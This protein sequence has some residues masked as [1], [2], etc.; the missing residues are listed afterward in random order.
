MELFAQSRLSHNRRIVEKISNSGRGQLYHVTEDVKQIQ[1]NRCINQAHCYDYALR[2]YDA[3]SDIESHGL[4][5][6]L[7]KQTQVSSVKHEN[8]L[9]V[10]DVDMVYE[11]NNFQVDI[12][13][14]AHLLFLTELA[15]GNLCHLMGRPEYFEQKTAHQRV[16][17]MN[18]MA[19]GI[20]FLHRKNYVYRR[21]HPRN[22]MLME[23]TEKKMFL[24][25]LGDFQDLTASFE[26][27]LY[28]PGDIVADHVPYTAPEI[29]MGY[30]SYLPA[31]DVWAYGIVLF[32]M[33]FGI[34][35][36]PFFDMR[37]DIRQIFRQTTKDKVV[38]NIFKW[39][40]TP[41]VEWRR[42]YARCEEIKTGA[43]RK[44]S[45]QTS[46]RQMLTRNDDDNDSSPPAYF[47]FSKSVFHSILD[48]IDKCLQLDPDDRITFQDILRHPLFQKYDF[49]V[50]KGCQVTLPSKPSFI[51]GGSF[52]HFR[53]SIVENTL[54]DIEQGDMMYYPSLLAM[55]IFDRAIP[56]FMQDIFE[57]SANGVIH[58]DFVSGLFCTCYLLAVKLLVKLPNHSTPDIIN[59]HIKG[60]V[61]GNT[62]RN[63]LTMLLLERKICHDLKF[64][65]FANEIIALPADDSRLF[66]KL[67]TKVM[68]PRTFGVWKKNT[69][70]KNK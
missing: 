24:G 3:S 29:L 57:N 15:S 60:V 68:D 33:L 36:N 61:C 16:Y 58:T 8:L 34:E 59:L 28:A 38:D 31:S 62:E 43:H 2:V 49:G 4:S 19:Q 56:L 5:A 30:D 64:Q 26:S 27:D 69:K 21:L 32:E 52:R 46:Y 65:F 42:R 51:R 18:N 20:A 11:C 40:G 39:L 70:R 13:K 9:N 7:L 17:I 50:T 37:N 63:R 45:L 25:K 23:E 12:C 53:T 48:L 1:R 54:Q 41:D 66:A 47:G 35:Q 55:Y 14:K 6:R 10:Y 22:V 67:K 44:K